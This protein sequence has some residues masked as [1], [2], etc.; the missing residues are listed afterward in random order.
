MGLMSSRSHSSVTPSSGTADRG[1]RVVSLTRLELLAFDNF[2]WILGHLANRALDGAL[3]LFHHS[4]LV[5]RVG[6]H[7]MTG[8]GRSSSGGCVVLAWDDRRVLNSR[9]RMG[10]LGR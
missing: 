10:S 4:R 9:G 6:R 3:D 8:G 1:G 5:V 7:G 2:F